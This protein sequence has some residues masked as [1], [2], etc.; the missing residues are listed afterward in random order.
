MATNRIIIGIDPGL[1]GAFASIAMDTH[2]ATFF[3]MPTLEVVTAG[4]KRRQVNAQAIV[5]WLRSHAQ[6]ATAISVVMEKQQAMPF[7]GGGKPCPKCGQMKSQGVVSTGTTMM[8][9]GLLLG[10]LAAIELPF[11][12]V[13]PQTWKRAM[14]K[15]M[16]SDKDA[17]RLRAIQLCPSMA[18]ELRR[19]KDHGRAEALLIATYGIRHLGV[20]TEAP[21]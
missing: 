18:G 10:I 4:K 19:K 1:D 17:S 16:G 12:L 15:D 3:D 8:N 7:R 9:Y 2:E 11:D 6:R 20:L 5:C 21:F 14:L 13:A